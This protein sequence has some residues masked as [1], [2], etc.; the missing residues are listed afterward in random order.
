MDVGKNIKKLRELKNFNQNHMAEKLGMSQ[1]NYSNIEANGNKVTVDC[2]L[3]I[4]EILQVSINQVLDLNI[5]T[6]FNNN[7]EKI[8]NLNNQ[9]TNHGVSDNERKLYEQLLLGKEDQIK[10]LSAVLN[11]YKK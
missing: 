3:K 10:Q 1:R 7:A 4:C 9:V 8:E 5:E 6:I 2:L 11:L